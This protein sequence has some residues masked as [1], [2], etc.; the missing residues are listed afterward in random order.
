MSLPYITYFS[1]KEKYTY[2]NGLG[3]LHQ[4]EAFPGSI[5]LV[6]NH[7]QHPPFGLRT[8]KISGTA[9]TAQPRS[10]NLW[11]YLYRARP[12]YDHETFEPYKHHLE[13]ANPSPPKHLTPNSYVWPTF[14]IEKG[15]WTV[16]HLLGGTGSATE[17][18]GMAVWLFHLDR[19]M[20]PQTAFS[21][22]DGEALIVPQVGAL[23][24]QTEFGNLLVRQNEVAVIP[25]GVKY[26]VTLPEGRHARG[27]V[28]ELY[29]G[30]FRLPDLGIIGSTGLASARDFEIPTA[31]FEGELV[32]Q[33]DDQV[34]V[35]NNGP[36]KWTIISRLGTKLWAATQG[37]TPFSVAG[38]Q[39]TLYPYKYDV[40]RFN[41]IGN[42]NFD[43]ADPSVFVILTAP[44][45]G[46]QPGTAVV[47]FAAVGPRWNPPEKTLWIP[48][49]H[50]NTASEFVFPIISEQDSTSPLN[51][52]GKFG[53]WGAWLNS[54]MVAHGSNDGEYAEWQAKDTSK[55][56]KLQD[57]GI[58][59]GIFETEN[60]LLLTDWA[61]KSAQKNFKDQISAA[62]EE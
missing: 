6:N 23:D 7:P 12:S 55:P 31:Y 13:T 11:T 62:F 53:P 61:F 40:K 49:Y 42:L 37:A 28:L 5:P 29:Q 8:E 17:K 3:N 54:N 50:R 36:G 46:K 59:A 56:E 1:L 16:Q 19:D 43:H 39:G 38:W 45:F 18:V 15:D 41:Y 30:H 4:S 32:S 22:Q 57:G 14:E 21:S 25:R 24:I 33:G 35:P 58:T 52:G 44:A 47:D 20:P 27:Y 34:A 26:R 48:W 9:L 51:T 10:N 2:L 60:A